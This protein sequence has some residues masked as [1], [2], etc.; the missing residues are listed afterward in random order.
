[1]TVDFKVNI[2][3]AVATLE[4]QF[5][6]YSGIA[7]HRIPKPLCFQDI[8]DEGAQALS[9]D[10]IKHMDLWALFTDKGEQIGG[11]V[12]KD[13]NPHTTEDVVALV[14]AAAEAFESEMEVRCHFNKGHYVELAPSKDYRRQIYKPTKR[15]KGGGGGDNIWPRINIRAGYDGEAFKST[16]GWYRDACSNMSMISSV[17]EANVKIVHCGGLQDQMAELIETFSLLRSGWDTVV[18]TI[19]RLEQRKVNFADFVDH[20]YE[21]SVKDTERKMATFNILTETVFKRVLDEREKTGRPAIDK[22]KWDGEVSMWEAFNAVQGYAQHQRPRNTTDDF[23][24]VIIAQTD[25]Y[26]RRAEKWMKANKMLAA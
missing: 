11:G 15:G 7:K 12:G 26:V 23:E 17:K 1:M 5:K 20:V 4:E 24:K 3:A 10:Q 18:A 13:Y 8:P 2:E 22:D 25:Y 19:E 21:K 16:V 14:R 9:L 6:D